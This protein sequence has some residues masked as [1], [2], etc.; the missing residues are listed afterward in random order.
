[1]RTVQIGCAA[2]FLAL[3]L[4]SYQVAAAASLSVGSAPAYPGTTVSLPVTA[5][6]SNA[7]VAAQFDAIEPEPRRLW[8]ELLQGQT[9]LAGPD[10]GIAHGMQGQ[11]KHDAGHCRQELMSGE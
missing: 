2:A 4:S 1:M 5:R 10:A 6:S 11:L 3:A 9:G 8:D 7:V